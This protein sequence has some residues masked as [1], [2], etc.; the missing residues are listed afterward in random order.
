MV[1]ASVYGV[2]TYRSSKKKQNQQSKQ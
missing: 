1:T 2:Y